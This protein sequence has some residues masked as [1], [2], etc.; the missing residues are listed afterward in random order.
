MKRRTPTSL[1]DSEEWFV[2]LLSVLYSKITFNSFT[3]F[4]DEDSGK[5][6]QVLFQPEEDEENNDADP[7]PLSAISFKSFTYV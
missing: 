7:R 2:L 6:R 1:L 4:Q 3:P 5:K